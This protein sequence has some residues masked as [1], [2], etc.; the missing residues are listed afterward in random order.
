MRAGN[1]RLH[2]QCF[3]CAHCQ[4]PLQQAFTQHKGAI[5]HLEC[6]KQKL[7]LNCAH[8]RQPLADQWLTFEGKKLHPACYEAHYRESCVHCGRPIKAEYHR[9]ESGAWHVGCYEKIKLEPC[10]AC[11]GPL[12][13]KIILDPWGN[14]AHAL[15][16]AQ[17][18][19]ICS[20]CA[21][22]VSES[23]S[24]NGLRYGDGRVVCGICTMTE[25]SQPAQIEHA[26]QAVIAQLQAV[27]FD[28][29]PGYISV[30][31]ADQKRMNQ[32]LGVH[33]SANSHGYTKTLEKRLG[34]QVS[35]EHSVFI[36]FGLPR[37]VFHGVLAHELLHV[38]LNDRGLQHWSDKE[39]EGFCNLGTA[40]VYQNDGTP[41]AQYLLKRLSEDQ[42]PVYGDGYRLMLA[43]VQKLGWPGL[44]AEMQKP[45]SGLNAGIKKLN[46]LI[47][48]WI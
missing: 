24:Q 13:G 48:R 6:Y 36:L 21:R 18:T 32:R 38:W 28:Y 42:N 26:K 10:S 20:I 27:G 4:Q 16:G 47:D 34:T 39:I 40:L 37:L 43:R 35:R 44:I 23:T 45:P 46:S 2:P 17:K 11:Q 19:Q 22:I 8:C 41:L 9:D 7:K 30:S 1:L 12:K 29:I 15:H 5:F 25:V 31:L 33:A 3:R 14:K